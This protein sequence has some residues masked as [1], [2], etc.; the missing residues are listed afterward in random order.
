MLKALNFGSVLYLSAL[1]CHTCHHALTLKFQASV[2]RSLFNH[3]FGRNINAALDRAGHRAVVF[4]NEVGAFGRF[5]LFR[6]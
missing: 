4:M 2:R 3:Q 5:P 1:I 6:L